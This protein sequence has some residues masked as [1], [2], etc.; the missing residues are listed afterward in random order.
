MP[1]HDFI[2]HLK[3]DHE[4]QKQ[5]GE[6]LVAASTPTE[7]ETLRKQFY[8]ELYP[9]M[10]GEEASMFVRLKEAEDEESVFHAQEALQE[11]HVGK[12]V[13]RELMEL[14]LDSEIFSAKAKVL[15]EINRH[16][17]EEEEEESMA[18][19]QKLCSADELS[20]LFEQY[21]KAEDAAKEE[22]GNEF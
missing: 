5:L 19:L 3:Q 8:T 22:A 11:H 9:H 14:S 1:D 16:H 7:R 6:K 18:A 21:E 20:A 13:L 4:E 2:K 12:I 15:D 10:I 17:I